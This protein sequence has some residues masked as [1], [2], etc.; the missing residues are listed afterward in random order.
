[1]APLNPSNKQLFEVLFIFSDS[2]KIKIRSISYKY[3]KKEIL[4]SIYQTKD[5]K[6]KVITQF[7]LL[8]S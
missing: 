7:P 3:E 4:K 1:M 5:V 8:T 2:R 6:W